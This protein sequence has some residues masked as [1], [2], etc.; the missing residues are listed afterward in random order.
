MPV[1]SVEGKLGTGKTKF[2]V[3]MAQQALIDG[4]RVA[5]NVDLNLDKLVPSHKAHY[6]RLPD[7]PRAFDLQTAVS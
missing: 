6:T 2:C 4:R 3:W 7:K 5:S 1:Y